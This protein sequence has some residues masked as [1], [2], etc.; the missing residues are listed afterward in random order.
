MN[1]GKKNSSR[2]SHNKPE[3]LRFFVARSA[4]KSQDNFASGKNKNPPRR[5]FYLSNTGLIHGW[6]L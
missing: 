2:K 4:A 6:L 1:P 3:L 5:K